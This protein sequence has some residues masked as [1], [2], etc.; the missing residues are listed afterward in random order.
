MS[1]ED[2]EQ[3]RVKRMQTLVGVWRALSEAA[4]IPN[5]YHLSS[6]LIN[7]VVE[8]YISDIQVIKFR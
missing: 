2:L 6:L 7:E 4:L 1:P 3:L 8:H 5:A